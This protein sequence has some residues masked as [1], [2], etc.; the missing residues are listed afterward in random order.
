MHMRLALSAC[1]RAK[2]KPPIMFL[3]HLY[4]PRVLTLYMYMYICIMY[5]Y[6]FLH[7]GDIKILVGGCCKDMHTRNLA[8]R[9]TLILIT[10]IQII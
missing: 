9:D 8:G 6:Y 5:Y 4:Y 7:S 3:L 10:I 1:E 2:I